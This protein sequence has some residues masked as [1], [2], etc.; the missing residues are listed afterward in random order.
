MLGHL[1]QVNGFK[2]LCSEFF[3]FIGRMTTGRGKFLV[4]SRGIVTGKT[5][6]IFL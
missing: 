5:V 3:L 4:G 6:N 2:D 1:F